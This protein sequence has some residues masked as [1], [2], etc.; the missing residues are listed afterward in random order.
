MLSL[1]PL[2]AGI[3]IAEGLKQATGL[4]IDL[5]WPNDLLLDRRKLAGVLLEHVP[6]QAAVLGVGVNVNSGLNELPARASSVS[7]ALGRQLRRET[8]LVAILAALGAALQRSRV[9][10]EGWV[11]PS[12]RQRSSMFGNRVSYEQGGA[13]SAGT[14]ED[15][16][17]DGA[18]RVRGDDGKLTR[19]YAGEVRL[20]RG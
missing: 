11:V 15:I 18:L 7:L 16:E 3:S 17:D 6:G 9:E 10:G 1:L 5:K 14:A 19:I 13:V 20:L 2:L 4:A 12:W 8:L